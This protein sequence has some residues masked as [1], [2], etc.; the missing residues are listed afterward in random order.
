MSIHVIEI[1][2]FFE[3]ATWLPFLP[4]WSSCTFESG[5]ELQL[6]EVRDLADRIEFAVWYS[7]AI[8]LIPS[9]SII[10]IIFKKNQGW[11]I[12]LINSQ[13]LSSNLIKLYQVSVVVSSLFPSF[14]L[15]VWIFS[16]KG[17]ATVVATPA[18]CGTVHFTDWF[19]VELLNASWRWDQQRSE[20]TG[21]RMSK[22]YTVYIY[23]YIIY[24]YLYYIYIFILYI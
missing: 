3:R 18:T 17:P 21:I 4:S 14:P 15:D 22:V 8:I 16:R 23:I 12:C 19:L 5:Q 20:P 24:I 2:V 6:A 10:L 13:S 7:Y 11:V 9:F 1:C